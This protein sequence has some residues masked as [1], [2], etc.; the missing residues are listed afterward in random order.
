MN[1]RHTFAVTCLVA[2]LSTMSAPALGQQF[3]RELTKIL[4]LGDSITEGLGDSRSYRFPLTNSLDATSC[5]Y[6]MVGRLTTNRAGTF[7]SNH[8]GYSGHSVEFFLDARS[9]NPGIEAIIADADPDVVLIHLG[10]NDMNR[11]QSIISTIDELELLAGRI[12][13]ANSA[14]SIYVANVIPWYGISNNP[15]IEASVTQLGPAIRDWV[16]DTDDDRLH[17]VQVKTGYQQSFMLADGIH[18]NDDGDAHIANAFLNRLTANNDCPTPPETFISAIPNNTPTAFTFTG[19]AVDLE[20]DGI[21]RVRVAIEDS[22]H[23]SN[24]NRWFNFSTGQF[25]SFSDIDA[26]LSNAT[27]TTVSWTVDTT[28]L[29]AGGSFRIYALAIDSLGNQDYFG[30]GTWPVN[31][32]FSTNNIDTISPQTTIA[33]PALDASVTSPISFSG[34][35]ADAGGSGFDNIRFAVQDRNTGR[36]YNFN[37]N[38]FNGATGNGAIFANLTGTSITSTNWNFTLP[39]PAGDYLMLVNA[40]DNDG[41]SSGFQRRRF[42]VISN[43]D[44]LPP[45]VLITTPSLDAVVTGSISFSGTASDAGGSG[46]NDIRFAIQDRSTNAWYNFTNNSFNG[47]TGNGSTTANLSNTTVTSTDWSKSLTLPAGNYFIFV[48]ARDNN[49][50]TSDRRRR[51]TVQ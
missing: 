32:G 2:M 47:A 13:A 4:P 25:G 28:N 30:R 17:L 1:I 43:N 15:S 33:F 6:Q 16:R 20:G 19:S 49:R 12:W 44:T 29:P 48:R 45:R 10:S 26:T 3:H 38:S 31:S 5:N 51:F 42:S 18:P 27:P 40:R 41:N 14:I 39:L 46:F 22:N 50:N 11:S 21:Q 35:A 34:S 9:N 7:T 23:T 24:S 36:W 8:E 37:N